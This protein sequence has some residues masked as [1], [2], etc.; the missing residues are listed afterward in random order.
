MSSLDFDVEKK[1]FRDFYE[2]NHHLLE[3]AK[4]SFVALIKSLTSHAKVSTSKV[5]GRVKN[6][7]ECI[8]KFNLKYRTGL[9][10]TSR[11]YTIQEHITDLIGLRVVC[12]YEDDIEKIKECLEENFKL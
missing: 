10:S 6:K 8:K 4:N 1:E 3:D 5:E 9:E 7:E 11:P 2:L 12:L